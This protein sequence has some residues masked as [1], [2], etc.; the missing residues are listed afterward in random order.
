MARINVNDNIFADVC[1]SDCLLSLK[2]KKTKV[3][4]IF[5]MLFSAFIYYY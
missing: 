3:L 2:L 1:P 4:T 5:S